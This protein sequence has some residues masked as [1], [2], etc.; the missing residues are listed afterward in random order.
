[1]PGSDDARPRTRWGTRSTWVGTSGFGDAQRRRIVRQNG[2]Y[3]RVA[4]ASSM[5]SDAGSLQRQYA[6][7]PPNEDLVNAVVLLTTYL[8]AV[9]PGES[10]DEGLQPHS[11]SSRSTPRRAAPGGDER[12]N[13]K[14]DVRRSKEMLQTPLYRFLREAFVQWPVESTA[15]L[16]PLITLWTTYLTPWS[17]ELPRPAR[18]SRASGSPSSTLSRG[19]EAVTAAA[20]DARKASSPKFAGDAAPSPASPRNGRRD[21]RWDELHVLHNVPF[22]CELM[23]HFRS[24]AASACPSTPRARRARCSSSS[25]RRVVPRV[26]QMLEEVEEAYNA[27]VGRR[28][29]RAA[30]D[31]RGPATALTVRP[32]LE[33]HQG[34]NDGLGTAR[35]RRD[36]RSGRNDA[37]ERRVPPH[38]RGSPA[39]ARLNMFALIRRAR[40]KSPWP[41]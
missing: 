3:A 20:A 1:M 5:C 35:A 8:F 23:R 7:N 19:I 21:A 24:S 37:N 31:E 22:Y 26:L 18:T 2:G 9:A 32:V 36:V 25:G 16:S 39:E 11:P 27:V 41:S 17:L 12:E 38:A 4:T 28:S 6:Y 30:A 33:H 14:E 15:S 40:R 29:V 13:A 34:T 10:V